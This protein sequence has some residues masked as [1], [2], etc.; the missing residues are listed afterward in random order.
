MLGV[1]VVVDKPMR[2][3]NAGKNG[4]PLTGRAIRNGHATACYATHC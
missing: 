1:Q 4:Q 3:F 2:P